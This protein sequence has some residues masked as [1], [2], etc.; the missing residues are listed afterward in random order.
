MGILFMTQSFLICRELN[1]KV[2]FLNIL[3]LN[4]SNVLAMI[5]IQNINIKKTF[6][7]KRRS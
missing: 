2:A 3:G 1:K 7:K 6:Y 4:T 5:D